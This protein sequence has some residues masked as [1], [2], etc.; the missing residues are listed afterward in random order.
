VV[1]L[2]GAGD[3]AEGALHRTV[4]QVETGDRERRVLRDHAADDVPVTLLTDLEQICTDAR[5]IHRLA[6]RG[7]AV[8]RSVHGDGLLATESKHGQAA[9]LL[10]IDSREACRLR[11]RSGYVAS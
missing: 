9:E 4:G 1:A 7:Q 3:K 5:R 6:E 11:I 8:S 10:W 2:V